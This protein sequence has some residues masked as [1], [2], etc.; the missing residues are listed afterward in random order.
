[1]D[2][3][4][5]AEWTVVSL[6]L[7]AGQGATKRLL[8]TRLSRG[9]PPVTAS[10]SLSREDS[11]L[12]VQWKEIMDRN[13]ETL[14]GH[15]AEEAAGWGNKEKAEWWQARAAVDEAVDTL[16][17]QLQERWLARY[18]LTPLLMGSIMEEDVEVAL[19]GVCEFVFNHA[20]GAP[21]TASGRTGAGA[22]AVKASRSQWSTRGKL[23]SRAKCPPR[24]RS[25]RTTEDS[26][27]NEEVR[28]GANG[29][30]E[31]ISSCVRG[32]DVMTDSGWL[33]VL[34]LVLSG[35][36]DKERVARELKGKLEER[37]G[38]IFGVP[39][40]S[41]VSGRCDPE[42]SGSSDA[43]DPSDQSETASLATHDEQERQSERTSQ[44][45]SVPL[46]DS[47]TSIDCSKVAKMR[48]AD[49]RRELAARGV[50]TVGAKLK[51]EL[52]AKLIE[53]LRHEA[54]G[55]GEVQSDGGQKKHID[56]DQRPQ[57][58]APLSRNGDGNMSS[59]KRLG[60]AKG[61]RGDAATNGSMDGSKQ[62][63]P[64][65][66]ADDSKSGT[67]DDHSSVCARRRHPV[68]LVLDEELQAM[69]WEAL[70]CLRGQAVSRVPAVP[71]VFSALAT[72]WHWRWRREDG[73]DGDDKDESNPSK[74]VWMPSQDGFRLR[75]GFYVLDPE[76]NLPSTQKQLRP[77]FEAMEQ[78]HGWSGTVGEAPTEERMARVLQ[79]VDVFAYS[80]HGA[81]ELLIGREAVAALTQCPVAVL[82]GCSSG[83]L[84]GYGEFEP[85]GMVSSYLAGGSPAVVANLWDVTDRDI[86]RFSVA[87]LDFFAGGMSSC[88]VRRGLTL[89]HAVAQAR[90]ECKMPFVIGHAPVC[91]GI[92]ITVAEEPSGSRG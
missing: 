7:A 33:A 39:G 47:E 53:A 10:V 30:S 12:L 26:V 41:S 48:V 80:G 92:P 34:R 11:E 68:I 32:G 90:S 69:P 52:V 82:M 4:L 14:R 35:V 71:F 63:L 45:A 1:M 44:G 19:R 20:K 55:K 91:Y 57:S 84:K 65:D 76:S 81:G 28:K 27:Q 6:C 74:E 66:H 36:R 86:D 50:S 83:R 70:P 40:I 88:Q 77:V 79:E 43:G 9:R 42:P 22:G 51:S 8:I 38:A 31:L 72:R 15:S 78:R 24:N 61:A 23:G 3:E 59:G 54:C 13:R 62:G 46:R 87:L 49:L 67:S 2:C 25:L 60:G 56:E 58:A 18:G 17:H 5:K 16:V 37:I 21:R 89:A 64:S 85:T 73:D 29:V 75:R